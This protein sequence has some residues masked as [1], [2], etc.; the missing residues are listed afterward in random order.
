[1]IF[2]NTPYLFVEIWVPKSELYRHPVYGWP[3]IVGDLIRPLYEVEPYQS[4]LIWYLQEGPFLQLCI[5]PNPGALAIK[6]WTA[7]V[8]ERCKESGFRIKR[9]ISNWTIGS[10]LGG[11]R[12]NCK[13]RLR[14][15]P[16]QFER[17]IWICKMMHYACLIHSD[18]LVKVEASG[19]GKKK[20]S[21]HWEVE[22]NESK[23]NPHANLFESVMH[24]LANMSEAK[25]DVVLTARTRWMNPTNGVNSDYVSQAVVPNLHL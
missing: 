25:F 22:K 1:M 2:H 21:A 3:S 19:R 4:T 24:L 20:V 6:E 12:W 8:R 10:A 23:Q 16:K 14:N 7:I 17:S 15:K 9:L 18:T 13:A 5:C 11:D